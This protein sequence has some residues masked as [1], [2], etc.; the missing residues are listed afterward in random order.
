MDESSLR[1]QLAALQALRSSLHSSFRFWEWIVVGGIV[2]ELVVL[3]K[4]HW[5]GWSAYHRATIRLPEKPNTLL[6]GLGVLGVAMVAGGISK[7]L[8]IDSRI[9]KVETQ[10]RGVNEQLYGAV[11]QRVGNV[12]EEA[13]AIQKRLDAASD[14]LNALEGDI[15]VQGPRW[16]ILKVRREE[17]VKALKPL[18][19]Q[20]VTIEWCGSL[21][22][23]APET[24]ETWH[25]LWMIL[26]DK[27]STGA[28]WETKGASWFSCPPNGPMPFGGNIV[29]TS[30]DANNGVKEAANVLSDALNKI[31]IITNRNEIRAN[32]VG[33]DTFKS[34]VFFGPDSPWELAAKDPTSVI[35]FVGPSAPNATAGQKQRHK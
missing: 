14:Q 29:I 21:F 2:I 31:G 25:L 16:N 30:S 6:F 22:S 20:K 11:S 28:G 17:F 8:G 4:E 34:P 15:V 13:D 35:L 5:D 23:S 33:P 1:A 27:T 3:V 18:A 9:E 32:E 26:S 10:I 7:E 12:S 19:G 24:Y